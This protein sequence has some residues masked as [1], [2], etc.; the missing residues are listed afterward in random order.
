M[1]IAHLNVRSL[2]AHFEDLKILIAAKHI[3]I[4]CLTE[5]HS[6]DYTKYIIEG[7]EQNPGDTR[8]GSII[9]TKGLPVETFNYSSDIEATAVVVNSCLVV[10]VYVPPNTSQ[11]VICT[12]F[13][14]LLPECTETLVQKHAV[15]S[16]TFT[17]D[18]NTG[19]ANQLLQLTTLFQRFGLQ[20]YIS[21]PTQISGGTLDLLFTNATNPHIV[22]IPT[23]FTDHHLIAAVLPH[24]QT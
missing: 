13:S 10:C 5:T 8:H 24:K 1:T 21:T 4:L 19:S 23:Y 3:D 11:N 15:T 9:Y 7:F 17:G 22:T 12:F 2:N 14:Q 20:Q 16:L 6:T 18:F